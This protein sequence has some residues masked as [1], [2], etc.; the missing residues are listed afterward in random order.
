MSGAPQRLQSIATDVPVVIWS[1]CVNRRPTWVN[2]G[3]TYME[4]TDWDASWHRDWSIYQLVIL[5]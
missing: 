2:R 4:W 5:C 1:H 3:L